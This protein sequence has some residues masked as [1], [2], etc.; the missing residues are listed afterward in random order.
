MKQIVS[1]L[2]SLSKFIGTAW[3]I[4][5]K[6]IGSFVLLIIVLVVLLVILIK[7]DAEFNQSSNIVES[8]GEE[9]IAY[10]RLNGEIL[11]VADDSFVGFNPFV[12]TPERTR[13]LVN[14]LI[15]DEDVKA[16]VLKI[17]SPGGSVVAS[18]EIYQQLKKLAEHKPVVIIFGDV[19]ASGGYYIATA[20]DRIVASPATLT[21]SIGVIMLSPDLSGLYEKVGV[22]IN[23]YKSGTFKDIGST[24]R[25]ATAEEV[26]ILQ[27]LIDDS[28]QLFVDRV[29]A[30]RDIEMTKLKSIADGRVYSGVQA[31]ENGL[32]DELGGL[33]KAIALASELANISDPTVIEYTYGGNFF[34]SFIQSNFGALVPNSQL[35]SLLPKKM[36]LYYLWE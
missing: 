13:K 10:A 12:I 11:Q 31:Y 17:N 4:I 8:G 5:A 20:A 30:E 28:Y 19:A 7:P 34:S 3:M 21:G 26:A 6:L 1:F 2:K 29:S 14:S 36:G 32:I 24:S 22:E 25:A 33:D 15:I 35:E 9:Q 23:T 18:E 27:S 16:I